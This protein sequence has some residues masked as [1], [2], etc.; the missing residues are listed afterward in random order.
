MSDEIR[1]G[2]DES[3]RVAWLFRGGAPSEFRYAPKVTIEAIMYSVRER[4]LSALDEP[5]TLERLSRCDAAALDKIDQR[6][7]KLVAAGRIQGEAANVA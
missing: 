6:I 2:W 7:A 4:G 5:A 1:P 3:R